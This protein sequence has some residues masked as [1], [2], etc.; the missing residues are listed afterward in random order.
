M[1]VLW[2]AD[3]S[4]KEHNGGAQQTNAVMIKAGKEL[5][6]SISE[7][8]GGELPKTLDRYD[9]IILNNITMYEDEQ[10]DRLLDTGKCIRYE[11]DYWV[12]DNMPELYKKC[13]HTIFLS[14]LHKKTAESKI[15]YKV[16]SSSL[17][18]SPIQDVFKPLGEKEPMSVLYVGN[19]CEMKGT[20]EMIKYIKNNPMYKFYVIGFGGMVEDVK[21]LKNVEYIGETKLEDTVKYYQKCE[22]LYHKPQWE[23]PFGRTVLEGYLC[24]CNLLVNSNVGAMSWDWDFSNYDLIKKNVQSQSKFWKVIKDEI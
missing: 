24:G 2:V 9:V 17:V 7:Y 1:K 21:N 10:L 20:P 11:H 22:Y 3:Y 4:T 18:P 8:T 15:G 13:K 19:L 14:P 23:E 5:G 6:Y 16:E 12:A